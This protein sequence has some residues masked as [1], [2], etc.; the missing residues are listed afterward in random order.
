MDSGD[1]ASE[2]DADDSEPGIFEQLD[3]NQNGIPDVE[4]YAASRTSPDGVDVQVLNTQ[5]VIVEDNT[6][7]STTTTTVEV[8]TTL[9]DG[10]SV[11]RVFENV[12]VIDSDGNEVSSTSTLV[13]EETVSGGDG[14]GEDES[15]NDGH[16]D[17]DDG[18][19]CLNSP[20]IPAVWTADGDHYIEFTHSNGNVYQYPA[21]YGAAAC[22]PWDELLQP[23]CAD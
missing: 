4:E 13:S 14:A 20:G 16:S 2:D 6:G 17:Q 18:C 8:L 3:L 15:G 10:T 5:T 9:P 7:M 1:S 22:N 12:Q 21:N 23:D 11:L 19:A